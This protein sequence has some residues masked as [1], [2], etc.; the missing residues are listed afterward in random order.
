MSSFLGAYYRFLYNLRHHY[1]WDITLHAWIIILLVILAVLFFFGVLPGGPI[2]GLV[3]LAAILFLAIGQR[4]ARRRSYV[5][6]T[7]DE[8]APTPDAPPPL[9]PDDKLKLRA[10]GLFNVEGRDG[11]FTELI[12]YYRTFETREHAIMARQ[13]PSRFL[14]VGEISP[15]VLGMWYIFVEPQDINAVTSGH[16]CFGPHPA[17]AL[18]LDYTRLNEKG[19]PVS[20]VAYLSFDSSAD[21][22]RVHADLLLDMGGPPR[23]PW[24]RGAEDRGQRTEVGGRRSEVNG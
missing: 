22:E 9:W 7:K 19:K 8:S 1:K 6:F 14:R 17:P 15:D 3:C 24:R 11:R 13:T 16:L 5:V 4:W 18:K 2:I 12:A 10:T 20:E 23:R 21:Q